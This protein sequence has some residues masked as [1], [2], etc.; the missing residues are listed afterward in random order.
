MITVIDQANPWLM[1]SR[2]LAAITQLQLGPH[3]IM[4]GTGRPTSQPRIRTRL[5]PQAS[6][7]WPETRLASALMTP[8]EM[9]KDTTSVVDSSLNSSAPIKGTTVR[10]SPTMPPTNALMRTRSENCCQ[11]SRR[12]S[13]TVGAAACREASELLM[14]RGF[15][16]C[17]GIRGPD[18]DGL[19]RRRRNLR[20]HEADELVLALDAQRLVVALLEADRRRRF[21][22]QPPSADRARERA[23]EHVDVVGQGL[24]AI[25]AAHDYVDALPGADG[26]L[27]AAEVSHHQRV[28]GEDEP[29]LVAARVVGHQETDVFRRM[30]RRVPH[31]RGDVSERQHV[32]ILRCRERKRDIRV[33]GQDIL[34]TGRLGELARR[35]EMIGVDVGVDH[36]VDAHARPLGRLDVGLDVADGI[37]HGGRRLASTAEKVGDADRLEVQKLAYDHG[38]ASPY[39]V[40]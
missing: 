18:A 11:F 19:G 21:P 14:S 17:A 3:M 16:Q 13:E 30:T 25:G 39:K 5:R 27:G 1:P 33:R 26:K 15:G 32:A 24:E 10:S 2:A 28:A 23:G 7:S 12:P 37:D 9:M 40:G 8:N 31:A 6:A 4:K 29:W 22:A 38:V 34:R 36:I 35:G 20:G